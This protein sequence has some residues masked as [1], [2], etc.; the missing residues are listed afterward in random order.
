MKRTSVEDYSHLFPRTDEPGGQ[1]F[2]FSTNPKLLSLAGASYCIGSI[3]ILPQPA[4]D[5]PERSTICFQIFINRVHLI[6]G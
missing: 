5:L 4:Q 2:P 3:L 1:L 6:G